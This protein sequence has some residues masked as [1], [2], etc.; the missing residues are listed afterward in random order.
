MLACSIILPSITKIFL[1]F[2]ELCFGHENEVK[3][4]TGDII[5]NLRKQNC[6]SCMKLSMLICTII[7]PN[8]IKIISNGFGVMAGNKNK[9][10]QWIRAHN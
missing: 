1:T 10:K 5:R 9:V 3:I 6:P 4:G 2:A 8:I 7:L